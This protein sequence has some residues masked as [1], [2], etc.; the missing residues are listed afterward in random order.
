[1]RRSFLWYTASR[2]IRVPAIRR[3]EEVRNCTLCT[4][5]AKHI[6]QDILWISSRILSSCFPIY[7]QVNW[8]PSEGNISVYQHWQITSN[9]SI[10]RLTAKRFVQGSGTENMLQ[11]DR[12]TGGQTKRQTD[13]TRQQP[14]LL[15]KSEATQITP[16]IF[17]C[18]FLH[19]EGIKFYCL[20]RNFYWN[21]CEEWH[22]GCDAVQSGIAVPKHFILYRSHTSIHKNFRFNPL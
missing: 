10:T 8:F 1:M 2:R 13:T 3:S 11:T 5:Y 19:S 4:P 20:T 18:S 7:S 12:Q 17:S 15:T 9:E 14:Q 21:V 6:L 16:L 22:Q